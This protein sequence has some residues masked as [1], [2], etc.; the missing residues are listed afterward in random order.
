MII[1]LWEGGLLSHEVEAI[2]KIEKHFEEKTVKKDS[3]QPAKLESKKSMKGGSLADQLSGLK[4]NAPK[5]Y[6]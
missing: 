1:E 3:V 4:P 2:E 5:K 6:Q